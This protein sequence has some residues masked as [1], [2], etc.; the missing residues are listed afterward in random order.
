MKFWIGV[1]R[2]RPI[3]TA[4]KVSAA[5]AVPAPATS[6]YRRVSTASYHPRGDLGTHVSPWFPRGDGDRRA[7]GRGGQQG[8]RLVGIRAAAGPDLERRPLRPRQR[9]LQPLPRGLLAPTRDEQQR[10][11]AFDRVVPCGATGRRVRRPPAASLPRR[12]G[13]AARAGDAPDADPSPLHEP[14]LVRP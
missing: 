11:P 2:A 4:G 13:R 6:S 1:S 7:P 5:A 3:V 9:L 14:R 12:A 8:E 10:A